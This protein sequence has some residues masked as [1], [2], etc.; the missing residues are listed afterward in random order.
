MQDPRECRDRGDCPDPEDERPLEQIG[1]AVFHPGFELGEARFRH[2]RS[3]RSSRDVCCQL[4]IRL[5]SRV[6]APGIHPRQV[7]VEHFPQLAPTRFH[8]RHPFD[9][10][11]G[12][13]ISQSLMQGA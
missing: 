13:A 5:T 11:V 1:E 9:E 12:R 7:H 6:R 8:V 10:V 2:G 3:P 4:L